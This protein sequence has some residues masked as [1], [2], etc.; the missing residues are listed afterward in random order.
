MIRDSSPERPVRWYTLQ[1]DYEQR[2]YY[3][4][5]WGVVTELRDDGAAVV[6]PLTLARLDAFCRRVWDDPRDTTN[7][8]IPPDTAS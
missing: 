3:D 7:W 8:S 6:R 2:D 5:H 1:A 4:F